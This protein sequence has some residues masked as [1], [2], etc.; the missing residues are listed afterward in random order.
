VQPGESA[1]NDPAIAAQ[2]GAVLSLAASDHRLDAAL[3]D[4]PP[5]PIVVIAAVGDHAAGSAARPADGNAD[6]GDARGREAAQKEDRGLVKRRWA[7]A[8]SPSTTWWP[9]C[10]RPPLSAASLGTSAAT[11]GRSWSAR[12]PRGHRH[13]PEGRGFIT[14]DRLSA[15]RRSGSCPTRQRWMPVCRRFPGARSFTSGDPQT[16][17]LP[18]SARQSRMCT[19]L[20]PAHAGRAKT[21]NTIG[22]F[23]GLFRKIGR[24]HV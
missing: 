11:T 20:V 17:R 8:R 10:T 18:P 23:A 7:P 22:P 24:A 14:P 9:H 4:Q 6:G 12:S 3:R 13:L 16:L 21:D 5:I 1:L 15:G 2:T 19:R